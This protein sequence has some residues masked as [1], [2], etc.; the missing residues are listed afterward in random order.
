MTPLQRT[1]IIRVLREQRA[2]IRRMDHDDYKEGAAD[3]LSNVVIGLAPV[4]GMSIAALKE[5]VNR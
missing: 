3:A 2:E 5:E 4:L 1:K